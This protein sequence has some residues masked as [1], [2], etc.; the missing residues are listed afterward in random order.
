MGCGGCGDAIVA[1]NG[2]LEK[3]ERA[4]AHLAAAQATPREAFVQQR[5]LKAAA[6]CDTLGDATI[7]VGP[8]VDG[9]YWRIR[10]ISKY[11]SAGSPSLQVNVGP[12]DNT[13][14]AFQVDW[15][16]NTT[17]QLQSDELSPIYVP[18]SD[19]IVVIYAGASA[20]ASVVSNILVDVYRAG[21]P[22]G[23]FT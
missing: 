20:S 11:A 9:T 3:L 18:Q 23:A 8:P 1:V 19:F 17:S 15:S 14:P 7:S 10:R 21:V 22:A 2:T 16:D 4:L 5:Y 6:V 13:D 12:K